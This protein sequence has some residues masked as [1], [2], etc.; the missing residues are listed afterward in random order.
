MPA[1]ARHSFT[2]SDHG[3]TVA[4]ASCDALSSCTGLTYSMMSRSS[5][6]GTNRSCSTLRRNSSRGSVTY[7]PMK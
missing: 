1:S 4:A 3:A 2:F 7:L 6:S 5:Y